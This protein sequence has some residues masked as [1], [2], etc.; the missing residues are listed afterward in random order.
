MSGEL[1]AFFFHQITG[2]EESGC[3]SFLSDW[4]GIVGRVVMWV[5]KL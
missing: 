5:G 4:F 3:M 1:R 2:Q